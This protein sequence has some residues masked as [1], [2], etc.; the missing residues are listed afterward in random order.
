GMG[1][2]FTGAAN[3]FEAAVTAQRRL[4]GATWATGPLRVR[5]AI[6]AGVAEQRDG[7]FFGPALNRVARLMGCAAGGQVLCSQP[8]AELVGADL[9]AGVGLLDLGEHR[10][11]D[12]ARPERILQMT[13]PDLPSDFPPLRTVGSQRHNLPVALTSFIGRDRELSE[14]AGLLGTARLLTL[15][16]VGGA[17]KTRLGLQ[18]AAAALDDHPEGVWMIELAPLREA[19]QVPAALAGALSFETNMTDT[20]DVLQDRLVR[21]LTT[22]RTLLLFDNCEHLVEPV[23]RLA[24]HILSHCP[25]VTIVATSR[26]VLGVAGEVAWRVPPL[27]LPAASAAIEELA[28]SDAI[29]FFCERTRAAR[30]GFALDPHNAP[31]LARICRRLDGIPLALELAAARVGVL[32][33]AQVADRLDD[34]FRLLTGRDRITVPRHHTLRAMVDWS[35]ELLSTPE[36][37]ALARLAVF[38]DT[39][40]LD[41]AEAVIG[42]AGDDTLDLVSRLV[43][44]SLVVIHRQDPVPRYRLLETIRVYGAEKLAAAGQET[45]TRRRHCDHFVARVEG[46]RGCP[47]GADWLNDIFSDG[48]NFRVALEW[49]WSV[50]DLHAALTLFGG[51]SAS[52][53]WLGSAEG[54]AWVNRIVTDPRFVAGEFADHPGRVDALTLNALLVAASEACEALLDE[55]RA[56]AMRIG[57]EERASR[58]DFIRG[59]FRLASH[60]GPGACACFESA[61]AISERLKKAD[62]VGW[63]HDHLGWAAIADGDQELARAH[64]ERAVM[65]ARSD[66][67]GEWLEPHAVAALAPL[68]ARA[69][70]PM[71]AARLAEEAISAARRLPARPLLAMTLARAAD[72]AIVAGQTRRA[73]GI[74]LELLDVLADLGTR[75]YVADALELTAVVVVEDQGDPELAAELLGAAGALR[76]DTGEPTESLLVSSVERARSRAQL[77]ATVGPDRLSELESRGRALGVEAMIARAVTGLTMR[78]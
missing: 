59:E 62:Q 36:Q 63:C 72:A 19:G 40:D 14:L 58:V 12:L 3:A 10:L 21:H 49:A 64:F 51:L 33:P 66:P 11:A 24:H 13:H 57:D 76:E 55:A 22:R 32:N 5:M 56:I 47:L 20:P 70:D 2:T 46:W 45:A 7:N 26:E 74:L 28:D 54:P 29:T 60:D 78:D 50:R 17:G 15:T 9:P 1:A 6:H 25:T 48:D 44:K 42:D 43:D 4:A 38:P 61:L 41:A 75:R 39:F 31:A 30:P 69:G 68:V 35:Y 8:A 18:A 23:A 73:A 27:S 53:F 77:A 34:R 65:L 37:A 71:L 52:W 67:I 16:G